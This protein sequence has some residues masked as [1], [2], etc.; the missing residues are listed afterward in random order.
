MAS[1]TEYLPLRPWRVWH[2]GVDPAADALERISVLIRKNEDWSVQ[3]AFDLG[4]SARWNAN[5]CTLGFRLGIEMILVGYGNKAAILG[6]QH[7]APENDATQNPI[8]K[9]D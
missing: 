7:A 1:G 8:Y 4:A 5:H 3:Y 9:G 2:A 6:W